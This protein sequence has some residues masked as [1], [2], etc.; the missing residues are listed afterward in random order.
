MTASMQHYFLEYHKCS[1][2]EKESRKKYKKCKGFILYEMLSPAQEFLFHVDMS[3]L[4]TL[5]QLY[6][7]I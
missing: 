4:S 1:T 3:F 2:V 6:Q 7:E 5:L